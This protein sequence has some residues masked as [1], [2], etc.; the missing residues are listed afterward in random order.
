MIKLLNSSQINF[1]PLCCVSYWVCS[2]CTGQNWTDIPHFYCKADDVVKFRTHRTGKAVFWHTGI[3]HIYSIVYFAQWGKSSKKKS[4]KS[5]LKSDLEQ[6][7]ILSEWLGWKIIQLNSNPCREMDNE[8]VRVLELWTD[9]IIA[10][11][12]WSYSFHLG[13]NW[14]ILNKA[15]RGLWVQSRLMGYIFPFFFTTVL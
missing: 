8:V 15:F 9:P 7:K 4:R 12:K 3:A 14:K 1:N 11:I 6:T 5:A 10:W 13:R 2:D